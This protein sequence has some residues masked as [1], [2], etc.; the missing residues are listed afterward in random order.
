MNDLFLSDEDILGK[1]PSLEEQS[2]IEENNKLKMKIINLNEKLEI[3]Q[4]ALDQIEKIVSSA[5]SDNIRKTRTIKIVALVKKHREELLILRQ[6][7]KELKDY[8]IRVDNN[9]QELG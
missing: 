5:I 4:Y 8:K 9:E 2:L 3:S 6:L 7:E 1:E